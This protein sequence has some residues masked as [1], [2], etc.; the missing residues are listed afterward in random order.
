MKKVLLIAFAVIVVLGLLFIAIK[1]CTKSKGPGISN[2]AR[3]ERSDIAKTVIA[4]GK[5]EPLYKAEIKSKIGGVVKRF[6]VEEGDRVA[7]GQKL[8]EVLPGTTPVE[9]VQTRSMVKIAAYEKQMAERSYH[10]QKELSSKNLL[11]P[12]EFDKTEV[13]YYSARTR[14]YAA[15]AQMRV[16]EQGA[17]VSTSTGE[18]E[19]T[20]EDRKEIEKETSEALASMTIIAP[21]DGIVLSRDMDKGSAVIPMSSAFGGTVIMTI[22]DI[23]EKHFK[24]DVDEAD[25]A[26]VSLGMPTR[27]FVEA[28]PDNPFSAKLTLISPMGREVEDIINFEIRAVIEDPENRLNVGMSADAEIILQEE[29]GV[30][31]IPEGAILYEDDKT[32]VN[33]ADST[34]DQG[35]RKAEIVKGISD[36]IRTEVVSGLEEGAVVVLPQ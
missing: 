35:F 10:R 12:D 24:G 18:I 30:L 22:A 11:S 32:F 1:G 20:D 5:V 8:V 16:L 7:A 21:L 6:F 36:G 26:R 19:M 14:F 33:V 28:Y 9:M 17:N 2:T 34:L 15:M 27:I 3:V 13:E 25:I 31:V 29:K 4:T 23:S